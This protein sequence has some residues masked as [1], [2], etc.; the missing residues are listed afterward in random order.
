MKVKGGYLSLILILTVVFTGCWDMREIDQRAIVD[1]V[2]AD[3]LVTGGEKD[4]NVNNA[5][6]ENQ[7]KK[8]KYILQAISPGKIAKGDPKPY[9]R[10]EGNG[11]SI[12]DAIKRISEKFGNFPFYPHANVY[13]FGEKL[14]SNRE[15]FKGVIDDLERY[16]QFNRQM[17]IVVAKGS[18]NDILD[19]NVKIENLLGAY[20]KTIVDNSQKLG[21]S[22]SVKAGDLLIGLRN[23]GKAVIP[24]IKKEKDDIVSDKIALIKDYNLLTYMDKKYVRGFLCLNNKL[25][26]GRKVI[27]SGDKY[28]S[29]AI[30]SSKRR[31]WLTDKE[32]LKYTIAVEMEGD[33][34][35]YRF[36]DKLIGSDKIEEIKVK[37]EESMKKELEDTIRY[38]QKDVGVDYLGIGEYTKKYHYDLYKKYQNNWDEMFKK[39]EF[40]FDVEMYIR[41]VGPAR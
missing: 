33:I 11:I 36:N 13:I 9:T 35:Q 7:P 12:A 24:C 27:V 32:N 29:Y 20:I 39:A 2:A 16:P 17:R 38:F 4:K 5:Y 41:R 30:V 6:F 1:V 21:N 37:L 10:V 28:I 22:I 18:I 40:D 26:K 23:E 14:I 25:E 15:V 31:I 8:V 34:Y 3:S 19:S